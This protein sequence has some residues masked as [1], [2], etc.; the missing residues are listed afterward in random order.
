MKTFDL[1]TYIEAKRAQVDAALEELLPLTDGP[2]LPV[3]QAMRYSVMAGGKRVRPILLMAGAEA[4]GGDPGPLMPFACAIECVHTYSLIHDDLP[5]MD[6]DDLRRGR[7]TC[8]KAYGEAVAILAGD[9]LLTLA[10]ELIMNPAHM[11]KIPPD[12]FR[13]AVY[14]LARAAGVHGMVGGQT[15][16]ILMENREIDGE[17][18]SYIHT[19]K[20]GALISA[21]VE[22]G[23]I[24]GGGQREQVEALVRYVD[25]LG[26]AFQVKD[27]LLD[28][29][30]DPRITGKS[31]GSDEKSHKATYPALY[32]IEN[33]RQRARDL[34]DQAL[35][36]LRDFDHLADP[37]RA[38]ASFV[39]ERE[40]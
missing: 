37:L 30:G 6:D 11:K 36:S 35:L 3:F 9:G 8:H 31:S 21:C 14:R 39:V 16:D 2:S 18:L 13:L 26:L 22:I 33:T 1:M 34:L 7:P 17:T 23:A 12:A 24:L 15:A 38:I 40:Y 20:T 27:D 25:A 5:A 4:V 29:E 10:F 32:G 28:V 19:R